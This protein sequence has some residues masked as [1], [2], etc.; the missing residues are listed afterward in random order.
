VVATP[1][2]DGEYGMVEIIGIPRA[3]HS[4]FMSQATDSVALSNIVTLTLLSESISSVFGTL[5]QLQHVL[6]PIKAS[7]IQGRTKLSDAII[8]IGPWRFG[9][10]DASQIDWRK[11]L[12]VRTSG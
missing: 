8:T 2:D 4:L 7:P 6:S 1:L 3:L 9:W 11:S 12:R 10:T 5:Y